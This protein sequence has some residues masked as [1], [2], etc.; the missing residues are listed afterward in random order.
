MQVTD[1][2]VVSDE[3]QILTISLGQKVGDADPE[4]HDLTIPMHLEDGQWKVNYNR[5]VD[6]RALNA[7][8]Q[9]VND[10][11]VLPDRIIR[12]TDQTVFEFNV[13]NGAGNAVWFGK[14]EDKVATLH[15]G[16]ET[17]DAYTGMDPVG[18]PNSVQVLPG[19]AVRDVPIYFAG[20]AEEYPTRID[21]FDWKFQPD[22]FGNPVGEPWNYTFQLK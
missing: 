7:A 5:V 13:N 15:F 17:R 11:S 8:A 4:A 10:V 2:K 14:T 21:L 16:S 9:V 1:T 12:F 6:Y 22:T 18:L 20:F 3:A 19:L